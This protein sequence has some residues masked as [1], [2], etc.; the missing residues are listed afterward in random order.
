M[1]NELAVVKSHLL[2]AEMALQA[3]K[4]RL[5]TTSVRLSRHYN[6]VKHTA[7]MLDSVHYIRELV[8]EDPDLWEDEDEAVPF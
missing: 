7:A 6:R 3:R 4:K 5:D 2:L 8:K 1:D